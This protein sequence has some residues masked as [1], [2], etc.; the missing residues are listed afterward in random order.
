[1]SENVSEKEQFSASCSRSDDYPKCLVQPATFFHNLALYYDRLNDE[2][3]RLFC[4]DVKADVDILE[5]V[6][7][8]KS[9]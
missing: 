4:P 8:S 3:E 7:S 1:M 9:M 2:S 6:D 5:Y